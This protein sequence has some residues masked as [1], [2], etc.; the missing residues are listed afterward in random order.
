MPG[1]GTGGSAGT[2]VTG[3]S[4]G[5]ASGGA[6]AGGTGGSG[7]AGAPA[8]GGPAGGAGGTAGAASGGGPT[9]GTG[10]DGGMGGEGGVPSSGEFTLT[11]PDHTEGAVFADPY[12][13]AVAG[14][15]GS[16]IPELHW[17]A[18]PAGTKSYAI[19]F[20]D[21]T[22]TTK[23]PPD[24]NG[25]HWAIYNIPATT[26]TLPEGFKMEA[27]IGAKET[28]DFLGPCPNFSGGSANTDTYKFTIYALE[29]DM[30]TISG[31]GTAAVKNAETLLEG[32]HLA[33]ATLSGTS[34]ASPP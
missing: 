29:A 4:G 28:G 2:A 9:G 13:C 34:S 23:M 1:A 30:V 27:S 18:G 5:Q 21:T 12:T 25:Y 31:S 16:I 8:G 14:F 15:N 33:K 19:T 24:N 3:G 7:G 10:M 20:I 26:L 22:L 11:S 32:M 17:T 6:P